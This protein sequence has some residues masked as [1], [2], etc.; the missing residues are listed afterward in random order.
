M[1]DTAPNPLFETTPERRG[2]HSTKWDRIE[3]LYGVDPADGLAMWTA[4]SDYQTAPCVIDAVRRAADHGVFGYYSG[5]DSYHAAIAW[6]MKTRHGWQ[7]D[8]DWILTTT[9]LGNA[10][11]LCIDVFTEPGAPV[12]IFSPVYHEFA[13]KIGRAGRVVTECP[14]ARDGDTY[15]LDLDDA[16]ARL[17]G[18]ERL[19]LWCSPQNPSGR[20]WSAEE[21]RAVAEFARA[22]DMILV[23]DEI[24]NDFVFEAGAFVPMHVAAPEAQDRMVLLTSASKTFNIAGQKTGNIIAPDAELRGRLAGRLRALDQQPN[25]LGMMMVEAAYS[26]AGAEWADAQAAHIAGNAAAFDALVNTIPGVRSLPLQS[27]YLAWV[28]FGGTGMPFE[29]I[30]DR[31]HKGARIAC[32]HGPE[33]GAP[34][35]QFMRFNLATSRARVE[36]AGRRLIAAF[37]DL[38]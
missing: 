36:E 4:D 23:S 3:A 34:G 33:F 15:V 32:S 19:L 29:E 5:A 35:A 17:T 31:I 11:G 30:R 12:A 1:T 37:D 28:D 38:Q 20:V 22:N 14:L 7:I 6:W 10:I 18:D 16:Q 26:P 2:T 9:G 25:M 24:H 21:L 13:S 27:T 8:A